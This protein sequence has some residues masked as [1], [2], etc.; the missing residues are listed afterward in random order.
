M[1]LVWLRPLYGDDELIV[2]ECVKVTWE[3]V[4][5]G[6]TGHLEP[7]P[8]TVPQVITASARHLTFTRG[9]APFP[10]LCG[11]AAKILL[12]DGLKS[13]DPDQVCVWDQI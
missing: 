8:G 4:R 13:L 9:S 12:S 5:V 2:P 3:K 11:K 7:G 6:A 10:V 1:S